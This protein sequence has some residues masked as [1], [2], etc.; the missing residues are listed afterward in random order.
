MHI[1]L[2]A[3]MAPAA[4][5]TAVVTIAPLDV[6]AAAKEGWAVVDCGPSFDGAPQAQLQCLDA[7]PDGKSVSPHHGPTTED[8]Q[9]WAHVVARARA[10]S[11]LHRAAL[12]AVDDMERMLIEVSCGSW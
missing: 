9:V 3:S 8:R 11:A 12:D 4:P 2:D 10:G 6:A 7:P 5:L 1:T